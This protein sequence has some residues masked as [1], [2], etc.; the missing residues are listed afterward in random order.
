ML[1]HTYIRTVYYTV[2]NWWN[3]ANDLLPQ[4]HLETDIFIEKNAFFFQELYHIHIILAKIFDM[5]M[6]WNLKCQNFEMSHPS[7]PFNKSCKQRHRGGGS[8]EQRVI[9]LRF[10]V[11][12]SRWGDVNPIRDFTRRRSLSF[13]SSLNNKLRSILYFYSYF[14]AHLVVPTYFRLFSTFSHNLNFVL[15]TWTVVN[16]G[17]CLHKVSTFA[18]YYSVL[19]L[20]IM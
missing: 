14:E 12:Q 15:E 7:K 6:K 2:A 11:F 16:L 20:E 4:K 5:Q 17:L 13:N 8:S 1:Q 19:I 10:G 18:N 3:Y 9:H